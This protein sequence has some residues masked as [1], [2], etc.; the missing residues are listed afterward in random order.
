[1]SD[2]KSDH[3]ET[4]SDPI[5]IRNISQSEWFNSICQHPKTIGE[6]K[7]LISI[8][9]R[10]NIFKNA[11]LN[12][13]AQMDHC[14]LNILYAILRITNKMF[15]KYLDYVSKRIF[16][17]IL[18]EV[19]TCNNIGLYDLFFDQLV[20][21]VDHF[22]CGSI[23]SILGGDQNSKAKSQIR[24]DLK[25]YLLTTF[26]KPF[27]Q[28]ISK[29][30]SY[31]LSDKFF[32]ENPK[33]ISSIV[34]QYIAYTKDN[35]YDSYYNMV[36][37]SE[38]VFNKNCSDQVILTIMDTLTKHINLKELLEEPC[39]ELDIYYEQLL[40]EHIDSPKNEIKNSKGKESA[41]KRTLEI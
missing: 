9:D 7:L 12:Q 5:K 34:N 20:Q 24:S 36:Y 31:D 40:H 16:S 33:I 10:L 28:Q 8:M 22:V 21:D 41:I 4:S 15:N 37:F 26:K 19:F 32:T 3:L 29:K 27:Y 18:R 17:G 23:Q 35:I 11:D 13:I 1:M 6:M 25:S 30:L 14:R 2:S 38:N 39:I